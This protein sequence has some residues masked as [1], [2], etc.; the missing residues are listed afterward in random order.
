MNVIYKD[1]EELGIRPLKIG[2]RNCFGGFSIHEARTRFF[3]IF[4]GITMG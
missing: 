2:C 3:Y 1:I 4:A